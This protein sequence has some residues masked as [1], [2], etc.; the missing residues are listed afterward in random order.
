MAKIQMNNNMYLSLKT[1]LNSIA[2]TNR[3][4]DVKRETE[5]Y[6]NVPI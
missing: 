4:L 6:M 1:T 2:F 3:R 5:H